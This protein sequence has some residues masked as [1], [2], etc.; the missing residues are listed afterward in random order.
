MNTLWTTDS[1]QHPSGTFNPLTKHVLTLK[2]KVNSFK[3]LAWSRNFKPTTYFRENKVY[4][5]KFYITSWHDGFFF[6]RWSSLGFVRLYKLTELFL[7][8]ILQQQLADLHNIIYKKEGKYV[9]PNSYLG[10]KYCQISSASRLSN[11]CIIF[12]YR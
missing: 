9:L 12:V 10:K 8:D 3:H 7:N 2:I 11:F 5:I 1:I 6:A 4:I